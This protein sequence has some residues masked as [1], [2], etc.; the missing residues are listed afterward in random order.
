MSETETQAGLEEDRVTDA[1]YRPHTPHA[2]HP[3]PKE[4][5]R[6]ALVLAVITMAEVSTYYLEPPRTL[7][8]IILFAFT[9]IKFALVALWFMHLKFDSKTYS[10]FFLMGLALA[11]TLYLIVLLTFTQIVTFTR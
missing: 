3:S 1:P 2:A 10:R 7:L 9:V 5:V 6:I 4:Y 8:I 11:V